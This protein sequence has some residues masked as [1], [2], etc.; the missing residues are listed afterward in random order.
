MVAKKNPSPHKP[1][2]RKLPHAKMGRPES[3][4]HTFKYIV[5][6][7]YTPFHRFCR[8]TLLAIGF[9]THSG[10]QPFLLGTL[11]PEYTVEDVVSF[12]IDRGYGTQR[13]AWEDDGEILSLRYVENF[14]YQ[15]HLRIFNDGEVRGHYEYTPECHPILHIQEIGMEDRRHEFLQLL[16]DRI[17][18]IET[19]EPISY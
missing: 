2:I 12:L 4:I 10:R 3:F 14:V 5:W 8:D 17:V 18:P 16:G 6:R 7:L 19:P 11:A 13:V 15:H 1:P 9:I